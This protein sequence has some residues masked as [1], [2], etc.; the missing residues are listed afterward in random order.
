MF[1]KKYVSRVTKI[2]HFNTNKNITKMSLFLVSLF[3]QS[4]F[5]I[6]AFSRQIR[7]LKNTL[8]QTVEL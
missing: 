4:I 1:T 3:V 5:A 8:R 2:T 7:K 6:K